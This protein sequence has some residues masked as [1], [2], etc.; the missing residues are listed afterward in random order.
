MIHKHTEVSPNIIRS[1]NNLLHLSKSSKLK[2]NLTAKDSFK[3]IKIENDEKVV[4]CD[5][6]PKNEQICVCEPIISY[7]K[8]NEH[9]LMP[10]TL[11]LNLISDNDISRLLSIIWEFKLYPDLEEEQM[12]LKIK[13]IYNTK[14]E[15]QASQM[16]KRREHLIQV[17]FQY[18]HFNNKNNRYLYLFASKFNHS[19][20]PNC[21]W[22][23]IDGIIKI[24]SLREIN[25][26]EE[27]TLSYIGL[28]T[29]IKSTFNR[30]NVILENC[31][32]ICKCEKC[33][34][35]PTDKCFV[36][37]NKNNLL[38]CSKCKNILYCGKTCQRSHWKIHKNDCTK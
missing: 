5:F 30:Q 31:R 23:I 21:N 35:I 4:A 18:N 10:S 36:C 20:N 33:I 27:C 12:L 6:I 24:K 26:S 1:D 38:S 19:C 32:F 7:Y 9:T 16:L 15:D 17:Y 11:A 34:K 25:Q 14:E 8:S 3:N 22:V 37:D 29:L 13:E 28:E 2:Y